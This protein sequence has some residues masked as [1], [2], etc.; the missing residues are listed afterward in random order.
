MQSRNKNIVCIRIL[1]F[2]FN[3]QVVLKDRRVIQQA[4]NEEEIQDDTVFTPISPDEVCIIY[5][6][7]LY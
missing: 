2:C 7:L 6:T 1:L 5:R 4:D 3:V